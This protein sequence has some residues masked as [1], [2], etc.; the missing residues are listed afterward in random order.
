MTTVILP[1]SPW[2]GELHRAAE[3]VE[4]LNCNI[5]DIKNVDP[6]DIVKIHVHNSQTNIRG[7]DASIVRAF[8]EAAISAEQ[9]GRVKLGLAIQFTFTSAP[10]RIQN[11]IAPAGYFPSKLDPASFEKDVA[12]VAHFHN[13]QTLEQIN[14][15]FI[16]ITGSEPESD[17]NPTD[18]V[19][20]N[21]AGDMR[22]VIAWAQTHDIPHIASC[23]AAH[24][25]LA[26]A[27]TREGIAVDQPLKRLPKKVKSIEPGT[28]LSPDH[29]L[30][31]G[32][33]DPVG[34]HITRLCEFNEAAIQALVDKGVAERIVFSKDNGTLIAALGNTICI[35]GHT[36]S[37][38][39]DPAVED[40]RDINRGN[41]HLGP[42]QYYDAADSDPVWVQQIRTLN[43]NIFA[44]IVRHK[45]DGKNTAGF[46]IAPESDDF[47]QAHQPRV[48]V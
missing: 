15:D 35:S 32:L 43:V 10:N 11:P 48:A 23:R 21:R 22:R 30:V 4:G 38:A 14:P 45:L 16:F 40:A 33:K 7:S 34:I 37:T 5:R 9:Q 27:A 6:A 2:N 41:H 20:D 26:E 19:S 29:P 28:I 39:Q 47:A 44:A 42:T 25:A 36:E 31:A 8:T 13:H 17:S 3:I 18:I 1:A 46:A 12:H 24:V